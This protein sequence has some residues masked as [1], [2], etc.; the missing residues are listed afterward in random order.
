MPVLTF[1]VTADT[2]APTVSWVSPIGNGGSTTVSSG[3]VTLSAT[4]SD[5]VGVARVKF[6][7]WDAVNGVWADI[8]TLSAPPWQLS[9]SVTVL[10]GAWN[11]LNVQAFDFAG[12]A[13]ASPAILVYRTDT[14][15]PN[16][17]WLSPV[18]NGGTATVSSGAVTFSVAASDNIAVIRVKFT[19][20]DTITARW[21]DVVTLTR[22]PWQATIAVSSF[23]GA[24]NQVNVQAWDSVG[25]ASSSPYIWVYRTVPSTTRLSVPFATQMGTAGDPNSGSNNCGPASITMAIRYYTGST[26]SPT[27]QDSAVAIRGYNNINNTPTDFKSQSTINWLAR[28]S[29]VER[30]VTTYD[31]IRGEVSAGRPVVVLVNNNA[32]RYLN[33][34]PNNNDGWFTPTHIVVVTGYDA[35][36]VYINDPLRGTGGFPVPVSAFAQAASTT[37]STTSSSWYAASIARS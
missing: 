14:S 1:T 30:S 25:N 19:R 23:N 29:L 22:P 9:L 11:Q 35:T 32:Y 31:Q 27:V 7:R 2:T 34:Y 28:Y 33:P 16:V 4:A 20:W 13:S 18:G 6:F 17:S 36:N 3:T 8:A 26:T 15:A 21:V 37:G 24:W 5:D 12:N 10:N